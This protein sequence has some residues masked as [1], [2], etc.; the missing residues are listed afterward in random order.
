MITVKDIIEY[1]KPRPYG[2]KQTRIT[3]GVIELSIVG[4]QEGLYGDFVETFE[5][6]VFD[7]QTR[8]FVTKFL[9]SEADDDVMA[10][11]TSEELEEKVN[12]LF[13]GNFQVL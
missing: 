7:A 13:K 5:I 11:V 3:N 12:L 1:S 10:F 9:F 8:E 4:G 6:A 2:G